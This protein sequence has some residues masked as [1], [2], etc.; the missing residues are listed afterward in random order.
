MIIQN[1]SDLPKVDEFIRDDRLASAMETFGYTPTLNAVRAVIDDARQSIRSRCQPALAVPDYSPLTRDELI[2]RVFGRLE[3]ESKPGIYPVINATGVILH[4]NLGRAPL[5]EAAAEAVHRAVSTY[6]SLE[7]DFEHKSRGNRNSH[8]EKLLCRL[9][10]VEAS[11][12]VNNNAAAVMLALSALA[13]NREVIVSRGELVEIGGS[14][15]IPEIIEESQALLREVGTTNR[16]HLQDYERLIG[17]ETAA[18]LKVHTSNFRLIGFTECVKTADLADLAHKNDLP[19]IYDL[20]SGCLSEQ[21]A[22]LFPDEPTVASAIADGADVICFSGDKLLGG[23]Q[24]GLIVG[25]ERYLSSMRTHP[26]LRAFRCGKMTL[27]ALEQTLRL[28]FD[29]EKAHRLLPVLSMA[30]VDPTALRQRTEAFAEKLKET[31]ILASVEPSGMTM[32]GGTT[33]EYYIDSFA[34][35]IDPALNSGTPS[36]SAIESK[37]RDCSPP[38][39]CRL[40]KDKLYFDLR[41]VREEEEASL[42]GCLL[43]AVRGAVPGTD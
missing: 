28:Y 18:I 19:F 8:I 36:P 14:F 42:I 37:L 30:L 35:V 10:N 38:V 32:G 24:A 11:I 40:V 29:E 41:T 15:R 26:L 21:L 6:S 1:L 9:L 39:V 16:T 25:K 3:R 2:E 31:G 43:R 23:P 7:F 4:T 13:R 17:R 12:V 20:G 33:P 5:A 22:A 34:C 27:T